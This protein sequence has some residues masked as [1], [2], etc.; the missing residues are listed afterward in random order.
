MRTIRFSWGDGTQV[1]EMVIP[2]EPAVAGDQRLDALI[3]RYGR[4]AVQEITDAVL[5]HC[6]G[7]RWRVLNAPAT[8]QEIADES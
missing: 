6:I 7:F 4:D 8:R 1:G 2:D 3:E 5:G